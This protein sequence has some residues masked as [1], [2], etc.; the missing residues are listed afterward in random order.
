[1]LVSYRS[2]GTNVTLN[3]QRITF[4]Y[5]KGSENHNERQQF[6]VHKVNTVITNIRKYGLLVTGYHT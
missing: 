1:M 3:Q 5:I 2:L 4:F 6:F